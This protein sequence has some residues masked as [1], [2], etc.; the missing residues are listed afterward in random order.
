MDSES[1]HKLVLSEV[2]SVHRLAYHLCRDGHEAEDLVQ[3]TYLRAL[4]S[5]D[6]YELGTFG[7]RPWLFKILHNTLRQRRSRDRLT[8]ETL[9]RRVER[10]LIKE[11]ASDATDLPGRPTVDDVNW[12]G[13]DQRLYQAIRLLPVTHRTVFLLSAVEDLKYREIAEVVGV[14]VGTVMSRLSRARSALAAELGDLAAE[15]NLARR[16]RRE[17]PTGGVTES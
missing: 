17:T 5:G 11:F 4:K 15:R 3:E 12:D 16:S 9:K 2:E 10:N 6:T 14:P 1:F 13:L 8:R 7:V